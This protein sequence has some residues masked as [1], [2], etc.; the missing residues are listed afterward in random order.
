M[1]T[2][3]RLIA[4]NGSVIY[5]RT[6]EFGKNLESNILII[7]R[8]YSFTGT[9]P[10]GKPE[11]L[12]WKAKYAV[13]GANVSGVMHLVDGINEQGL[14]GG[15]FYF[16]GYAEYQE[17]SHDQISHSI[18]PWEL[19]TWILTNFSTIIEL[20]E[21]LSTI[22]VSKTMFGPWGIIPPVH[23]IV[24]D[25]TGKS[26]VIEYIQGKCTLY[27]NELGVITNSPT[28]DW[29]TTNLQNYITLSAF[30]APKLQLPGI[31]LTPLGQ[32]SGMLGLPGDFTS[33]S[34]F[35]RAVAFC[36]T[37][38]TTKTEYE[39]INAAFHLLNL[40]NIP[41]GV[42]REKE[43]NHIHYDYT[44]WTSAIDLRNKRYYFHTY[45]NRQLHI[46]DF[47]KMDLNAQAPLIIQMQSKEQILTITN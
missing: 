34:R 6:L 15:L 14:A 21:A 10:S 16:P 38:L 28:F 3:I 19:I 24:H 47:M 27:D 42:V 44:Q 43:N 35:V 45:E 23:A 5:G 8:N 13:T 26:L 39:T 37:V 18:A 40:F 4:Q 41:I 7:P 25:A 36:L 32:G 12:Q 31:S 9:A 1:C 20:K 46:V 22:R 29:H 11:G 17:V 30:N 2:G 33:P